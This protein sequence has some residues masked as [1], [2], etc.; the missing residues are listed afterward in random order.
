MIRFAIAVL[1][2]GLLSVTAYA[3]FR[4]HYPYGLIHVCDMQLY[5]ALCWYAED[6]DGAFPAGAP[7]PQACLSVLNDEPYNIGAHLL[8]GMSIDT[9]IAEAAL[10]NHGTLGPESCSWQYVPGLTL[11]DVDVALFWDRASLD[12][13]GK[14]LPDGATSYR[15][16]AVVDGKYPL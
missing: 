8:S 10:E 13:N 7:T 3:Y 2:F 4:S 15:S 9:E 5:H 11:S 12:H 1:I 16:L 6:H 14:L